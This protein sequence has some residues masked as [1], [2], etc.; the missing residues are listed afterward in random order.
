MSFSDNDREMI[1]LVQLSEENPELL[2]ELFLQNPADTYVEMALYNAITSENYYLIEDYI[3]T[4]PMLMQIAINAGM[5]HEKPSTFDSLLDQQLKSDQELISDALI[6]VSASSLKGT[7][8]EDKLRKYA[9]EGQN[10]YLTFMSL[11]RAGYD[12][13][14]ALANDIWKSTSSNPLV[15]GEWD[16]IMISYSAA[17]YGNRDALNKFVYFYKT[18][19][20]MVEFERLFNSLFKSVV[21]VDDYEQ[22]RSLFSYDKEIKKW[23]ST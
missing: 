8:A 20:E 9:V 17:R 13:I 14:E 11:E 18:S 4:N 6:E 1:P 2:L 3:S 16:E 5:H 12:N 21:T 10:R 7:E 23:S 15:V 22:N 19:S